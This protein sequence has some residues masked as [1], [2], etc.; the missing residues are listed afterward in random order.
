MSIKPRYFVGIDC[1]THTG[2]AVWD[3]RR[4]EFTELATLPIHRALQRVRLLSL[5][6]EGIFVVVEDARQRK[7]FGSAG[8]EQLQGAGSVKRDSSIWDDFLTDYDIPHRMQPPLKGATKWTAEGFTRVTGW[9][10]R[11]SEHARDA[12][13]LVYGM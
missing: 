9:K 3:S 1:G 11:T 12:A 8:R 10:G 5:N 2:L 6:E 13:L 4:K 7:W